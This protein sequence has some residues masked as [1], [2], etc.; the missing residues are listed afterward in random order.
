MAFLDNSGDI[1]L[2]AVL[3][4]AGRERLARGDG[5]FRIVK[6]ALGDD[7][8]NYQLYNKN[9]ANGSA[10]YDLEILQT[11]V[12]EAFT[13]NT[14]GMKSKLM[15][16]PRNNLLYLPVMR[17]HSG[18]GGSPDK[19]KKNGNINMHYVAVDTTTEENLQTVTGVIYGATQ[20]VGGAF[21][22]LEQGLDTEDIS[23]SY[24]L[25]AD[26]VETQ[27]IIQMDSRLGS[28]VSNDGTPTPV[29][30]IDDDQIATYYLTNADGNYVSQMTKSNAG[31]ASE[32][33]DTSKAIRGPL[34]T[35]LEFR[36]KSSIDLQT[37]THL[38]T[39]FGT[40]RTGATDL[41][42]EKTSSNG[43]FIDS[44]IKVIGGTT[45][46]SMDVPVRFIKYIS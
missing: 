43:Y 25:D 10:Y 24:T 42:S 4:D 3:T 22:R 23:Q 28:L 1:I 21:I 17:L 41:L 26:L 29:S 14:S 35:A 40:N 5:S 18:H 15:T 9:H 46:Y 39:K 30:F 27:Y 16:I 33:R 12:L 34:G 7:E 8:I 6:F 13:N 38:F 19:S 44:V 45:G 2:D 31:S 11:P 32:A 37:G 20:K 36:I